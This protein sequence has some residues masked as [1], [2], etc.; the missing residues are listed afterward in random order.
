MAIASR[1]DL[2][3]KGA[4]WLRRAGNATFVAELPD[5]LTIAEGRLNRELG[6]V[7]TDASL[8]GT[9]DSRSLD[10][11]A[12]SIVEP[13]SL[14]YAAASSEDE[15]RINPQAPANMAYIDTSG[16]P[17]EWA[18]LSEDAIKLNRPC[19]QAYSFRFH[20]RQR[21]ALTDSVTTNWLLE[22][23]PDIYLAALLMWG[24]GYLESWNNGSIWK[25]ILDTE[26][27]K[28]AHT[29]AKGRKGTLTVD[30][31]LGQIGHRPHFNYT[32]GV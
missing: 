17:T 23:H 20:Y 21:F 30:P 4:S 25:G 9:V 13:I 7:E 26:L 6:P 16:R 24:C 28:V 18:Y 1:S 2:L 32:T 15:T 5:A 29:L 3:T 19:D 22:K 12:L 11:S 14:F 31:A 8:T 27:P 10:I